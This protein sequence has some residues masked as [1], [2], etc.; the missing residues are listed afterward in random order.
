MG[1][2]AGI[3][4]LLA[5]AAT[6]R[7]WFTTD[8]ARAGLRTRGFQSHREMGLDSV[9]A[10]LRSMRKQELLATPL[11][12]FHVIVLPEY[13]ALGCLPAAQ[14]V[15]LLFQFLNE[16]YYA[17]LLSAA[18]LHGAGHQHAQV[19]QVVVETNRPALECGR[20]KVEFVAR[21]NLA[22]MATTSVNTPRGALLLSTPEATAFD[23]VTYVDRAGGL[24]NVVTALGE[25]G[26]KMKVRKFVAQA[27]A[28]VVDMPVL[29][30]LGFLL[31]QV[32]QGRL[33]EVLLPIVQRAVHTAVLSTTA[34]VTP[35]TRRD[36]RWKLL[37]NHEIEIE[38]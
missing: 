1:A 16:P 2:G 29:Q 24:D 15:P 25:L 19:F 37:I 17:G 8:E 11:R 30:R 14:L 28:D 5:R 38:A 27:R 21:K 9:H 23:L 32:G 26:P 4:F 31:E 20:V 18:E 12:G 22:L 33:A 10:T 6:G 7:L 3:D 34:D 13:R 35:A 36:E